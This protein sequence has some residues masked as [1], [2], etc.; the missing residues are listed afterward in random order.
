MLQYE[1]LNAFPLCFIWK[2]SSK[3]FS[4]I[5]VL[6]QNI[7]PTR[8]LGFS[9]DLIWSF[10]GSGMRGCSILKLA[11]V[12]LGVGWSFV[13]RVGLSWGGLSWGGVTWLGVAWLGVA[14]LGMAWLGVAWDGVVG[15]ARTGIVTVCILCPFV[16]CS[17]KT[18]FDVKCWAQYGHLTCVFLVWTISMWVSKSF[19][20]LEGNL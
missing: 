18:L 4:F 12:F 11:D 20:C 15:V 8:F 1:H 2:W 6:S 14:W 3:N 19:F 10:R 9:T 7:H 5:N 17:F 13:A 16:T